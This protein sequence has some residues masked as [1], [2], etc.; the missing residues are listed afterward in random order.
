VDVAPGYRRL[1][2][3]SPMEIGLSKGRSAT[4]N[5]LFLGG[6]A[7]GDRAGT[8]SE[9]SEFSRSVSVQSVG[10]E[11][12]S[13]GRPSLAGSDAVHAHYQLQVHTVATPGRAV[14]LLR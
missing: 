4:A 2:T 5:V 13:L 7:V 9:S 12:F 3:V 8:P 14:S 10:N 6:H 1:D 11:Q